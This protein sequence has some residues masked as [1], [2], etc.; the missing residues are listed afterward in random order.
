MVLL[1][2]LSSSSVSSS[3]SLS[4][5]TITAI[6]KRSLFT[7]LN[8][9]SQNKN[10]NENKK[11]FYLFLNHF[12]INN[13]NNYCPYSR[14]NFNIV[15]TAKFNQTGNSSTAAICSSSSESWDLFVSPL[16]QRPPLIGSELNWLERR[17]KDIFSRFEVANSLYSDHE[18][19]NFE[20]M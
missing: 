10:N 5:K 9:S 19:R 1:L 17:I 12:L 15:S 14:R 7:V 3:L 6:T 11:S 20:D 16:I 2:L 4:A 13:N 8:N 18:M